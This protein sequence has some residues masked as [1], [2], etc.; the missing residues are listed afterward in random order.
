MQLRQKND[1]HKIGPILATPLQHQG[2]RVTRQFPTRRRIRQIPAV[3]HL[4]TRNLQRRDPVTNGVTR[5]LLSPPRSGA[6][7]DQ[8]GSFF[9]RDPARPWSRHEQVSVRPASRRVHKAAPSL[10]RSPLRCLTPIRSGHAVRKRNEALRFRLFRFSAAVRIN[11]NRRGLLQEFR[12]SQV[13]FVTARTR[14]R[15]P[16]PNGATRMDMFEMQFQECAL[17]LGRRPT[18]FAPPATMMMGATARHRDRQS[19]AGARTIRA[20]LPVLND[21]TLFRP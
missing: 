7:I 13:G 12:L 15:G 17:R 3:K 9:P 19:P 18:S 2:L 4:L 10:P 20:L 21:C 11:E 6:G 16:L 8:L 1:R 5:T 14:S